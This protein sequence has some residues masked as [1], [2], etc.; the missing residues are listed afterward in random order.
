MERFPRSL[1]SIRTLSTLFFAA[2][3]PPGSPAKDFLHPLL[4]PCCSRFSPYQKTPQESKL[5]IPCSC[6]SSV[7]P[8]KSVSQ[9]PPIWVYALLSSLFPSC[10][11]SSRRLFLRQRWLWH[12]VPPCFNSPCRNSF[13]SFLY[14]VLSLAVCCTLHEPWRLYF[15]KAPVI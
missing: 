3:R 11:L 6:G 14:L 12:V 13:F 2:A 9:P 7:P 5:D 4:F 8:L 10:V 1:R 15:G